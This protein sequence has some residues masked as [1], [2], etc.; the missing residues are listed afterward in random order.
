MKPIKKRVISL[1]VHDADCLL[2]LSDHTAAV[3]AAECSASHEAVAACTRQE[4][5][6]DYGAKRQGARDET[7]GCHRGEGRV[8]TRRAQGAQ[9]QL[10]ESASSGVVRIHS[11][12]QQAHRSDDRVFTF[13]GCVECMRRV[14][15]C[16]V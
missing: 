11:R 9:V 8:F 4:A 16:T 12:H 14:Q 10:A 2:A 3:H 15:G 1:T 13:Q 5:G 6:N 7:P